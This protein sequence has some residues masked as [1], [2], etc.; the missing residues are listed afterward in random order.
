[1]CSIVTIN[2]Y[3]KRCRKHLGNTVDDRKCGAAR[4]GG[5][6]YHPYPE[7]RTETYRLKWQDCKDCQY[8]YRMYLH[9]LHNG[10]DWPEPNP[11]FT[12]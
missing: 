1:M 8:E 5:R 2:L 3:C 10:L 6:D 7:R 9:A 12:N 11:P 4:Q